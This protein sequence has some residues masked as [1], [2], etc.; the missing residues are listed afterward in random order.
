MNSLAVTLLSTALAGAAPPEAGF[1]RLAAP[2]AGD[3]RVQFP[4]REQSFEEYRRRSG[5]ALPFEKRTIRLLPFGEE[6]DGDPQRLSGL[7]DF[8]AAYFMTRV[9]LDERRSVPD[10]VPR[11]SMR[12]FGKQILADEALK[13]VSRRLPGRTVA[14]L[15]L[16]SDD[17]YAT[18]PGGGRLNFVFGLGSD[19][20][21]AAVCSHVRF[22]WRYRGEPPDATPRKRLFKLAAHEVGHVFGL[23]HCQT[24][25]CLMNGSNSLKESDRA[26]VHLCPECL[27]KLSHHLGFEKALRYRTLEKRY[28]KLGWKSETEFAAKRALIEAGSALRRPAGAPVGGRGAR[29]DRKGDR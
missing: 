1:S 22:A 18:L 28:R 3:W 17:L 15:A 25:H 6:R 9:E 2:Q 16:C 23:A 8:L 26:P 24:Y 4:E 10:E 13:L 12:G 7:K 5:R 14:R 11:R 27:K 20:L 19:R 29:G 21:R